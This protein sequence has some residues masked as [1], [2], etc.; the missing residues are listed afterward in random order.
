MCSVKLWACEANQYILTEIWICVVGTGSRAVVKEW[1]GGDGGRWS[2]QIFAEIKAKPL[3]QNWI[4]IPPWI[5]RPS[6]GPWYGCVSRIRTR[7]WVWMLVSCLFELFLIHFVVAI[8]LSFCLTVSKWNDKSNMSDF[9]LMDRNIIFKQNLSVITQ[10]T[11]H[12]E[13]SCTTKTL[14]LCVWPLFTVLVLVWKLKKS[15]T[16]KQ[17]TVRAPL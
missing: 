13:T 8:V 10:I 2:P 1:G 15:L 9:G 14:K 11:I 12:L 5:F 16:L 17:T 6:Y 4:T 7:F 3:P